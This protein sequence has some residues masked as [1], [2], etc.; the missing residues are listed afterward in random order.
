M[1]FWEEIGLHVSGEFELRS[2]CLRMKK[3][4]RINLKEPSYGSVSLKI[5]DQSEETHPIEVMEWEPTS[6]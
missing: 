1:V 5:T 3:S 6:S 4:A 2:A